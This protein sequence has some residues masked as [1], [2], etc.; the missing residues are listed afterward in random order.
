MAVPT[1]AR[2]NGGVFGGATDLAL[3]CDFRIGVHGMELRM[4][5]ARRILWACALTY[6]A[7][8][9]VSLLNLWHWIRVLR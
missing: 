7:A 5:A 6:V 8:S 3:A 1:V 4:P 9:L 2:L